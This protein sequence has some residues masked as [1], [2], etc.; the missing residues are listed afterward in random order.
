MTC[1]KSA[2]ASGK[3]PILPIGVSG[4]PISRKLDFGDIYIFYC[5]QVHGS[6]IRR[7]DTLRGSVS[8]SGQ[9]AVP[10]TTIPDIDEYFPTSITSCL[11]MQPTTLTPQ[12]NAPQAILWGNLD[13]EVAACAQ[14]YLN[15]LFPTPA[16][17]RQAK[18]LSQ[19]P[20][21]FDLG[22]QV[23]GFILKD[24]PEHCNRF[25][26]AEDRSVLLARSVFAPCR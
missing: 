16:F 23:T 7:A 19:W 8:R 6:P 11:L 12:S 5:Q 22:P 15:S 2:P 9:S 24:A 14:F 18:E 17:A 21:T 25:P 3:T 1:A 10:W 13:G 4:K 20:D 26:F